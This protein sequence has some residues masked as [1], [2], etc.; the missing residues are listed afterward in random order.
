MRLVSI[1]WFVFALQFSLAIL[2]T[3]GLFAVY[4]QADQTIMS[5]VTDVDVQNA[6][7]AQSQVSNTNV[8]GFGDFVK[9]LGLFILN[10]GYIV[11]AFPFWLNAIGLPAWLSSI[12]GIPIYFLYVFAIGQWLSNRAEKGMR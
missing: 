9:G 2:N 3:L 12:M 4:V 7:Y 5:V 1:A 11:V 10:F 6:G 8:L